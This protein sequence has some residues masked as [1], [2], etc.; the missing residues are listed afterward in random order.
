MTRS[1]LDQD[2]CR[3]LQLGFGR[4]NHG[5]GLQ[6]DVHADEISVHLWG[7]CHRR[8]RG[9]LCRGHRSYHDGQGRQK[10]VRDRT[11]VRA[12]VHAFCGEPRRVNGKATWTHPRH[13]R[14]HDAVGSGPF[15]KLGNYTHRQW[16]GS[17]STFSSFAAT[18]ELAGRCN[19]LTQQQGMR[20]CAGL[21]TIWLDS[22]SRRP[23]SLEGGKAT[24]SKLCPIC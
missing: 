13:L 16:P 1:C 15:A 11:S 3:L 20:V 14:G 22:M 5:C 7:V 21:D 4:F 24:I 23:L 18:N 8:R 12:A 17:H 10:A 9:L 2:V 6:V 19:S